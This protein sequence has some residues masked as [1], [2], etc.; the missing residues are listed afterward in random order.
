VNVW[1]RYR[2]SL[3]QLIGAV[4]LVACLLGI[5]LYGR[6]TT[7]PGDVHCVSFSPNA[8][9]LATGSEDGLIRLWDTA[10]QQHRAFAGHTNLIRSLAFSPD[11]TTLASCSLD[12]RV[13]LWDVATG[14][15][16][17]TLRGHTCANAVS[18]SPDGQLLAAGDWVQHKVFVWNVESQSIVATLLG[19]ADSV[20]SVSFAPD[21]M[22][23]ASGSSDGT[24]KLWNVGAWTQRT[25][26]IASDSVVSIA[27]SPDGQSLAVATEFGGVTLWDATGTRTLAALQGSS[28]RLASV[29]FSPNGGLV[30]TGSATEQIHAIFPGN[31]R[32]T[33]SRRPSFVGVKLWDASTSEE[34]ASLPNP[35]TVWCVAFSADGRS[36]AGA[37]EHW[38]TRVWDVR[39]G[40]ER[41]RLVAR[42]PVSRVVWYIIGGAIALWLVTRTLWK[43]SSRQHE[44]RVNHGS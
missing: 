36:L 27:F 37:S 26:L 22:T 29:A 18:F 20:N 3:T 31:L 41:M 30:A 11:G 2:F 6:Y 12:T 42:R 40:E 23:L 8:S 15:E 17:A 39:S 10:T 13:R 44:G 5:V 28:D 34:R 4:A 9:I 21:G 1:P 16:R 33:W 38:V 24:V 43:A 35:A 7:L 25:S 14:T 19:H 32:F